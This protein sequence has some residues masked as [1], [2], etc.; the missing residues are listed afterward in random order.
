MLDKKNIDRAANQIVANG[1]YDV[2]DKIIW[3]VTPQVTEAIAEQMVEKGK[4]NELQSIICF[5]E[6]QD[7]KK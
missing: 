2:L 7:L 6:G 5:I 1:D 4:Y 3:N